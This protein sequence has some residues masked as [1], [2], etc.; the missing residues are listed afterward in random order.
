MLSC[1]CASHGSALALL[2]VQA[3]LVGSRQAHSGEE[4][5]VQVHSGYDVWAEDLRT[6]N[7]TGCNVKSCHPKSVVRPMGVDVMNVHHF[8]RAALGMH[9]T[10]FSCAIGLHVTGECGVHDLSNSCD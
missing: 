3:G 9:T 8:E 4:V 1:T 2:P 6:P 10:T 5:Q 7:F